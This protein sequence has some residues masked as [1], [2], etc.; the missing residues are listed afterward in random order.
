MQCITKTQ[1]LLLQ[2]TTA[3]LWW[4]SGGDKRG[5]YQNCS[6]L[7]SVLKL[8]TVISTVRWAVLT[9]LWIGFCHTGPMP[10]CVDS[11]V[12][13]CLYFVFFILHICRVVVTWW[14]G[15]GGIEA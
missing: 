2:W 1:L 15:S 7:Y 12:F 14:G 3:E 5:D 6:V 10:L 9:V 4:L 11:L 8:C 13:M